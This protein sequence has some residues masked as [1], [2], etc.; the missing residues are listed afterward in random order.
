MTAP[1]GTMFLP[2]EQYPWYVD[3]LRNEKPI[4]G[5]VYDDEPERNKINLGW[6]EVGERDED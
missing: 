4:F 6:E 5:Y 2:S 1:R 3:L